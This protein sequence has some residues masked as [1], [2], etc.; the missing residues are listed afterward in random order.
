MKLIKSA[1]IYRVLLPDAATLATHL[2][3][4]PFEDLEPSSY[5][6]AGFIAPLP[7]GPLVESFEN[8]YAFKVR[9]DEKIIPA[10]VTTAEANK[11]ITEQEAQL[12][13]R[14]TRPERN[15]IREE[16]YHDLK[17]KALT[18]IKTVTCFYI[19]KNELL[20]VPTTS[21]SLADTVT[22][23]L[24]KVMGSVKATTIY[25]SEAKKGLTTRLTAY[26]DGDVSAFE[27]FSVGHRCKLKSEEGQKFSFDLPETLNTAKDGLQEAISIHNA[28]VTE[29]EL[30]GDA[31]EFRL[32]D[33]FQIK[34]VVFKDYETPADGHS[35][36]IAEFRHEAFVQTTF[37]AD[38]VHH[39]CEMFD[40]KPPKQETYTDK[41]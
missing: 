18:R 35:D 4:R 15:A 27:Q 2:A 7:N 32:T 17:L 22:M 30:I 23:N 16:V 29:I 36:A 9:Y 10:S 14:L 28:Q 34:S 12:D 8:G 31:V 38:V 39:L 40:Y 13:R 26:L 19:P 24:V 25:V 11:K 33:K 3:E 41:E 6:G 20:I 21:S 1:I 5:S 37:F